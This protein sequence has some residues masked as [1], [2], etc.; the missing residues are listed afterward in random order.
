MKGLYIHIPFCKSKCL[1][2]GFNSSG[3]FT[4]EILSKYLSS[5]L[6]AAES[7]NLKDTETIYIGG[8]TP[9]V[10][11]AKIFDSFLYDLSKTVEMSKLKEFTIEANPESITTQHI[12]VFKSY[13]V[14]RISLGAQSFNDSVL[15]FLGRLHTSK[16]I[17]NAFENIRTYH[18]DCKINL[19][20]IFDIPK[21]ENDIFQTLY[22]T[23][24]LKPEHISAYNYSFDTVFLNDYKFSD[25]KT[26]FYMVKEFLENCGYEKYE[27]SNFARNKNISL[28]NIKY[29]N[30]EEYIGIGVSAH[31]MTEIGD[32]RIRFSFTDVLSE[33][34]DQFKI[35]EYEYIPRDIMFKEDIIFG[36]RMIT[37]IDI[38]KILKKYDYPSQ[39]FIKKTEDLIDKKLLDLKENRL[40]LSE[41]GELFLDY[42]QEYLWEAL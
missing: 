34:I 19:D 35:R 4:K 14:N 9:T 8:G 25:S 11:P 32:K 12:S 1:Y 18:P 7:F 20:I 2:C 23:V 24:S 13:N 30:M 40:C 42:V 31:S 3:N 16:D 17:S 26:D 10:I 36:L 41:K 29:W 5:I 15:K 38:E 39:E 37:G 22:Q 33:F 6:K 21:I 28:H 27:I